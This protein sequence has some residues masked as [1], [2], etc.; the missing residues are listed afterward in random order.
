VSKKHHAADHLRWTEYHYTKLMKQSG[1][2]TLSALHKIC[3][4]MKLFYNLK[5]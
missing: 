5:S 2:E 3:L 1:F 4:R